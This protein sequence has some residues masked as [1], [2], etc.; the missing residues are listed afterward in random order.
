MNKVWVVIHNV[1]YDGDEII[2]VHSSPE[3]AAL[4]AKKWLQTT[5]KRDLKEREGDDGLPYWQWI[6]G[7]VLIEKHEV[8]TTDC[9]NGNM[10]N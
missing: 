9:Q 4:G 3:S 1:W 8:E 2:S 6:N 10:P 7:G 5:G